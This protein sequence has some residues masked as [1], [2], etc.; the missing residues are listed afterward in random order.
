MLEHT[1]P[2]RGAF[3][4]PGECTVVVRDGEAVLTVPP[5]EAARMNELQLSQLIDALTEARDEV[6]RVGS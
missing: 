3:G 1:V 4:R 5:G 6:R 2:C